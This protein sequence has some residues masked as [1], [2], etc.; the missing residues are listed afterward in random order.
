MSL[1]TAIQENTKAIYALMEHM[2]AN[3]AHAQPVT[4]TPATAE[5]PVAV[6]EPAQAEPVISQTEA[7]DTPPEDPTPSAPAAAPISKVTPA[8][9]AVS[10]DDAAKA[11]TSVAA[12]KGKPAALELLAKYGAKKLPEVNPANF[13]ELVA[14]AENL[15]AEVLAA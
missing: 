8:A 12:K 2:K 5:T 9:K 10:Y 13:A 4:I 14:D 11:V 7:E 6:V 1:E 15:L 3:V